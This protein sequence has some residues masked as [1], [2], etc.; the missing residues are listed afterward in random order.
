MHRHSV[1][2]H[3]RSHKAPYFQVD[4]KLPREND[5]FCIKQKHTEDAVLAHSQPRVN[6]LWI[7]KTPKYKKLRAMQRAGPSKAT[8]TN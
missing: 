6:I 8:K 7:N 4:V 3:V 1:C 5:C 2:C